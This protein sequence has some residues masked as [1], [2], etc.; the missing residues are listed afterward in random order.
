[1]HFP[2]NKKITS[3][4]HWQPAGPVVVCAVWLMIQSS[5]GRDI[6]D[7]NL[8]VALLDGSCPVMIVVSKNTGPG[9]TTRLPGRGAGRV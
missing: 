7:A 2:M 4:T 9:R 6:P 5:D 3:T 1:M 8:N